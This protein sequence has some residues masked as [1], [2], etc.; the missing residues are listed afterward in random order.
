VNIAGPEDQRIARKE[1]WG[2]KMSAVGF[3]SNCRKMDYLDG[4]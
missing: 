2:K 1:V 4:S 3:K